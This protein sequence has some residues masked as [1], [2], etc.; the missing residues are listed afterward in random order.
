M[1]VRQNVDEP[2]K[3]SGAAS[4]K[5]S[6]DA[7]IVK[8]VLDGDVNAFAI[9][10]KRHKELVLRVVS[11][12]M[13]YDMV[14]ETAHEVFVRAYKSLPTFEQKGD[15]KN[16]LSVIAVRACRDYWRKAYRNKEVP[17]SGL[18]DSHREWLENTVAGA[19]LENHGE[20]RLENH[21]GDPAHNP[22]K[23]AREVLDW[24][25]GKLSADD[26]MV[27]ELVY[28]EERSAKET[29][30]LTGLSVANVKVRSFRA[31]R[32]LKKLL[33]GL[34]KKRLMKG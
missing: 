6:G 1:I 2:I 25:L 7:E 29:A 27:L 18:S 32:K 5:E 33:E 23:E 8:R 20:N 30:K 22:R 26:R 16:W 9:L 34:S 19:S 12:H 17:M 28:L 13:E 10:L 15:F 4:G 31:K 11:R 14:E 21:R 3:V 24:A